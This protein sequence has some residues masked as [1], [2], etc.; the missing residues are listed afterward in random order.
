MVCTHRLFL[1]MFLYLMTSDLTIW[2]SHSGVVLL[3]YFI[4]ILVN[5][6]R[7]NKFYTLANSKSLQMTNV[8]FDEN[9]RNFSKWVENT[10]GK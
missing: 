4:P 1:R 8:K 7:N 6:F 3:S 9:D 2:F 5:P 10:L